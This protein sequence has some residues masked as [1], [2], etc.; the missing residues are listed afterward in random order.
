MRSF[1]QTNEFSPFEHLGISIK[2]GEVTGTLA[3]STIM[4]HSEFS[5]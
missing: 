1:K 5:N 3:K 4:R 2:S